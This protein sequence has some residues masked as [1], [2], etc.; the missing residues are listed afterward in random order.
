MPSSV[1]LVQ[2]HVHMHM[3]VSVNY[4]PP[5]HNLQRV[6]HLLFC[7]ACAFAWTHASGSD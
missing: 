1:W 6:Q 2:V 5:V 4:L 3:H 7:L